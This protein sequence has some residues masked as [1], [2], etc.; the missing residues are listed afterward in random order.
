[1]LKGHS[2]RVM[3]CTV[4]PDGSFVVSGGDDK[5]LRIW[6][7]ATARERA[8]LPGSAGGRSACAVTPDGL[9]IVSEDGRAVR[10]F[11]VATGTERTRLVLPGFVLSLA[12]HPVRPLLVCGD[13]GG[14][15][16]FLDLIGIEYC[17]IVVTATERADGPAIRCPACWEEHAITSD[18]LG[19]TL[20]C[21]TPG[22][23]LQ[24][25]INPF[26]IRRT[27]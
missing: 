20:V 1:V 6:D 15:V 2:D 17:P 23:G 27:R 4:S 9:L 5:S 3:A 8:T 11:D 22:C 19:S 12:V 16:H 24:L 10:L 7:V 25:R 18:Q 14:V 21:A 26:V 13:Q